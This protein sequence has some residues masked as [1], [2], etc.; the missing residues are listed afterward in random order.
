[1]IIITLNNL[2]E[3]EEKLMI[4]V[5][6]GFWWTIFLYYIVFCFSIPYSLNL[7]LDYCKCY[8]VVDMDFGRDFIWIYFLLFEVGYHID[9]KNLHNN[10][11]NQKTKK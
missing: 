2:F 1:V 5:R 8:I 9:L 10:M 6:E 3:D 7:F 4:I 11:L